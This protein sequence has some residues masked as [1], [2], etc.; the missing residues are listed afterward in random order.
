MK[1]RDLRASKSSKDDL[2]AMGANRQ[3]VSGKQPR[4]QRG[5]LHEPTLEVPEAEKTMEIFLRDHR[6]L[7]TKFIES[8]IGI[9]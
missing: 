8:G 5:S 1:L 2:R 9:C 4:L 3:V 7:Q 6:N